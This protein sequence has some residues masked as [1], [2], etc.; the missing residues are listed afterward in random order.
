MPQP[1]RLD[2]RQPDDRDYWRMVLRYKDGTRHR[3]A[4]RAAHRLGVLNLN[5]P[6]RA[7][8]DIETNP[9]ERWRPNRLHGDSVAERAVDGLAPAPS[10]V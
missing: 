1:S 2:S 5:S 3:V 4:S 10:L 9:Q 7:T 8:E 6:I